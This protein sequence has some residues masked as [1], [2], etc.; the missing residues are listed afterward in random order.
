MNRV[1]PDRLDPKEREGQGVVLATGAE[2]QE[3]KRVPSLDSGSRQDRRR[4]AETRPVGHHTHTQ[5]HRR[6]RGKT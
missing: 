1:P 5:T 4:G 2:K 3:R 6:T